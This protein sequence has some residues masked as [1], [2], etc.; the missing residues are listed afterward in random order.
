MFKEKIASSPFCTEIADRCFSNIT[1]DHFMGDVSFLTT[2]RALLAPRISEND[3]FYIS[4][5]RTTFSLDGTESVSGS[6]LAQDILNCTDPRPN[7]LSIH[8]CCN[9][10]PIA[11]ENC[12]AAVYNNAAEVLLADWVR[13][14]K[15]TAMFKQRKF[16]T[17]CFINP[18]IRSGIVFVSGGDMRRYHMVQASIPVFLPWYFEADKGNGL[19]EE[20][21][22]L[23]SLLY[24]SKEATDYVS[25]I[26]EMAGKF[27]FRAAKIRQELCDFEN[28]IDERRKEDTKRIIQNTN[29]EIASL[30]A[31]IGQK[32]RFKNEQNIILLGIEAKI[33]QNK[34]KDS[35]LMN[36]FLHNSRLVLESVSN[37]SITF[38]VKDYILFF[39]EVNAQK[40]IDNK[41]S[42]VYNSRGGISGEDMALLMKSIFVE[43]TLKLRT[44]AAYRLTIGEG[45]D[46]MQHYSFDADEYDGYMPNTHVQE[47]GCLGDYTEYLNTLMSN[48]DYVGAIE[49]CIASARSLNFGDQTVMSR[50]VSNLYSD[51]Y[52]C[53]ELPDGK[54]VVP[55]EAI[56]W[57]KEANNP[58]SAPKED[59]NE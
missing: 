29:N 2:L 31:S 39:D 38:A 20:E 30:N 46:P 11:N 55:S 4:V 13:V 14:D 15:V 36:Y 7:S 32:I 45:I 56:A 28:K 53:I 35:E 47:Y 26:S 34:E 9:S 18:K 40:S 49:Q 44:C 41:N 12:V 42:Y 10:N 48:S 23:V 50:F 24:N 19:T 3:T 6:K 52:R 43:Q 8:L 16:A 17:A 5:T 25:L 59:E 58:E 33:A 27:D 22:T 1:G 51:S 21:F 54:V 37:T 57:L